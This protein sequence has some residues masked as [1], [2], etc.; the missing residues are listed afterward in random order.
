M[1]SMLVL[2]SSAN[3]RACSNRGVPALHLVLLVACGSAGP[4]DGG[5]DAAIVIPDAQT[6]DAFVEPDGGDGI[7]GNTFDTKFAWGPVPTSCL[8]RC[9]A[10]TRVAAEACTT[11]AC[12]QA[13]LAADPTPTVHVMTRTGTFELGCAGVGEVSACLAWQFYS[14][15]AEWCPPEFDAWT[16]CVNSGG[17][18]CS[19][20]RAALLACGNASADFGAC[21]P[22]RY[23]ACYAM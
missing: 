5:T 20:Q 6:V 16:S 15:Q 17:G 4:S 13:A 23:G 19:T 14:C 9:T 3:A 10:A 22:V 18:D 8:P 11:T 12:L 7:C 2:C 1:T 21:I